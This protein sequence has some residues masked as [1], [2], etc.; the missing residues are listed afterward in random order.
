MFKLPFSKLGGKGFS[1][2]FIFIDQLFVYYIIGVCAVV[3]YVTVTRVRRSTVKVALSIHP[4]F[5]Y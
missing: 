4:F 3:Y 2:L 5:V 1:G